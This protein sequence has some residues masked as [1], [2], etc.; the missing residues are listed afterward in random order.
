MAF[1]SKQTSDKEEYSSACSQH[2]VNR[3]RK[4]LDKG[5]VQPEIT[6]LR[7]EADFW[8][9]LKAGD[10]IQ[11]KFFGTANT[12]LVELVNVDFKK[13]IEFFP[14]F[15]TLKMLRE[16]QFR[17]VKGGT[18]S[19]TEI[20]AMCNL[21]NPKIKHFCVIKSKEERDRVLGSKSLHRITLSD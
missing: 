13:F 20:E 16:L 18:S 3:K 21:T 4:D 9:N 1:F 17:F 2:K 10:V 7:L 12:V 8:K 19:L 15:K 11:S 14:P 6:I 5:F